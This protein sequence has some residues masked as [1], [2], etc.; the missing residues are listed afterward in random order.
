ML[1]LH[2]TEGSCHK[3]K[4]TFAEKGASFS[5]SQCIHSPNVLP[6]CVLNDA[7]RVQ[8]AIAKFLIMILTEQ[9]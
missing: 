3:V 5:V 1:T 7:E 6:Y 9:S 8:F 4:V 2:Q